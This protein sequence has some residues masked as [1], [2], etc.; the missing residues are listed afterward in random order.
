[1][2]FKLLGKTVEINEGHKNYMKTL[3]YFRQLAE[4]AEKE[5]KTLKAVL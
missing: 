3:T 5:L 4:E 2:S 1:M